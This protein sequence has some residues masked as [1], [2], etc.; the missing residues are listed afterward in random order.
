MGF[1]DVLAGNGYIEWMR[2]LIASGFTASDVL[3]S[4]KH[5]IYF[6]DVCHVIAFNSPQF[7]AYWEYGDI[8]NVGYRVRDQLGNK[9]RYELNIMASDLQQPFGQILIETTDQSEPDRWVA[10]ILAHCNQPSP[11]WKRQ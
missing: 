7:N 5:S 1:H 9:V 2:G 8:R 11:A 4:G 10:K 3:V 6:D